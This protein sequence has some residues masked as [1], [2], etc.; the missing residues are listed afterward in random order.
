MPGALADAVE[1]AP[2]VECEHLIVVEWIKW[3]VERDGFVVEL[4]APVL[5]PLL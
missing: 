5:V 1:A 3:R 4:A 2:F